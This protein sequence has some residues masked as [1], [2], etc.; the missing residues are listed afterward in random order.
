[1]RLFLCLLLLALPAFAQT[2]LP[3]LYEVTGVS[4][5]DVLNIRTAPTADAAIIGAFTPGQSGIEVISIDGNWGMVNSGE[6]SGWTSMRYLMQQANTQDI[7]VAE[8]AF[9]CYGTEP[10][11]SLT[12][13]PAQSI[14]LNAL[15]SEK[16]LSLPNPTVTFP[17]GFVP[18]DGVL[19]AKDDTSRLTAFVNLQSCNDGM[20]D[21]QF[22]MSISVLVEGISSPDDSYVL[23]GCCTLTPP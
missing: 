13:T 6:Q 5:D 17:I 23:K 22:G 3:A 1:M 2:Q 18:R 11:W 7:P 4:E 15:Y 14:L 8:Q 9:S 10:F 12:H 16:T 20:S 19:V 21:R